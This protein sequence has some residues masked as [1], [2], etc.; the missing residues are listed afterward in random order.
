MGLQKTEAIVLRS[1]KLGEK[2]K[3]VI[4]F[5]RDFGKVRGVAKSSRQLISRF[6]SCLE[7]FSHI[8]LIFFEKEGQELVKINQCDLLKSYFEAQQDLLVGGHLAYFSEL[9][10]EF[11]PERDVSQ[12]IFRL[13][14]ELLAGIAQGL[15]IH[16]IA[17][18]FELWLLKLQ[19]FLPLWEERCR[20]CSRELFIDSQAVYIQA[21]GLIC[22]SCNSS[23]SA[24]SLPL[25]KRAFN[26]IQFMLKNRINRMKILRIKKDALEEIAQLNHFLIT[27]F[28]EKELKSYQYLKNMNIYN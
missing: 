18:Y 23:S 3:I 11:L 25:S 27:H 6:G 28:L 13:V 14:L 17:R 12:P 7:L 10:I 21:Q 9:I 20:K 8:W 4:F 5:T 2:D 15:D 16:Y 26:I 19:G 22:N 1:Y 24:K